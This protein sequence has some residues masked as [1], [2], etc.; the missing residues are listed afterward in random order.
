MITRADIER[1]ITLPADLPYDPFRTRL[2]TCEELM[3]GWSPGDDHSATLDGQIY[4]RVGQRATDEHELLAQRVHDFAIDRAVARLVA[5]KP[6]VVGIMGSSTTQPS[7]A[8]YARVAHLARLLSRAGFMVAS[9]GGLGIMEAANLGAFLAPH[10]ESELDAAIDELASAPPFDQQ[11][12]SAQAAYLKVAVTIRERYSSGGENLAIPTWVYAGEPISQFASQIAKYFANSIREDGLLTISFAGIVFAEGR[13]GTT[14][15]IFQDAAKKA[16]TDRAG[17][18]SPM[19]FLGK[20]SYTSTGL[21]AEL[22]AQSKLWGPYPHALFDEPADVVDYL[23]AHQPRRLI[24]RVAS[25]E[26]ER[27]RELVKA[28]A[29]RTARR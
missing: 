19:A 18:R 15:E 26:P 21:Y 23:M 27:V 6:A 10:P 28:R 17:E 24:D 3:R 13:A 7:E 12:R 9:G 8:A 14:Q 20:D 16:D 11:D 25:A 2:Y 1:G 4:D 22:E 5:T 29:S